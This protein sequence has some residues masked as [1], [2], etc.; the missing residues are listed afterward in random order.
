MQFMDA[1]LVATTSRMLLVD[2]ETP[3]LERTDIRGAL[4]LRYMGLM[5]VITECQL[6]R[7][8]EANGSEADI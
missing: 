1:E 8:G 2:E 3:L 6:S 5:P 4:L 7:Q